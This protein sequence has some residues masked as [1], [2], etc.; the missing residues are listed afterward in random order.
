MV[1]RKFAH[2][3]NVLVY[4]WLTINRLAMMNIGFIMGHPILPNTYEL[5]QNFS[6]HYFPPPLYSFSESSF[7][8]SVHIE[9]VFKRCFPGA[10]LEFF[11]GF[12]VESLKTSQDTQKR[13]TT[14]R[15]LSLMWLMSERMTRIIG[16]LFTMEKMFKILI[17]QKW[18]KRCENSILKIITRF[19]KTSETAEGTKANLF[20]M[21]EWPAT[22]IGI[23]D[24]FTINKI[25]GGV[26]L[27]SE[28]TSK[29]LGLLNRQY[30][31]Q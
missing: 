19:T 16:I 12:C 30:P 29:R 6:V 13:Q 11:G 5:G 2:L 31:D 23:N 10:I 18:R 22:L 21:F 15:L 9:K 28:E 4:I 20:N 3:S 27:Q 8:L 24:D 14:N 17:G 1:S 26:L 7:V 25:P